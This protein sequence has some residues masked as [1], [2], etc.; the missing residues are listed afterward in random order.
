MKYN[1]FIFIIIFTTS[2]AALQ[3][4]LNIYN[5]EYNET[6]ICYLKN[7]TKIYKCR[8]E[9]YN[10]PSN[11][12]INNL[13]CNL[14]NKTLYCNTTPQTTPQCHITDE[15]QNIVINFTCNIAPNISI[16]IEYFLSIRVLPSVPI[17]LMQL[18]IILQ[19][20]IIL[21]PL[22]KIIFNKIQFYSIT[23]IITLVV[24]IISIIANSILLSH[25]LLFLNKLL[26]IILVIDIIL[27][28]YNLIYVFI[29]N[30][31]CRIIYMEIFAQSFIST[32]LLCM[33][34]VVLKKNLY[35]SNWT[36][37]LAIL[38]VAIVMLLMLLILIVIYN[39]PIQI[40]ST[41]QRLIPNSKATVLPVNIFEPRPSIATR[42][43]YKYLK[44]NHDKINTTAPRRVTMN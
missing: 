9:N 34:I 2:T 12:F 25:N 32:I 39:I 29:H 36:W 14:H 3:N 19:V 17:V 15:K 43:I 38:T 33:L 4:D 23:I 31:Y 5:K 41:T 6:L 1:I 30:I 44:P 16:N 21:M 22:I 37:E 24:I 7:N 40:T 10:Y 8:E 11:K 42:H 13:H 18:F 26:I 28:I 27:V 35:I 20:I